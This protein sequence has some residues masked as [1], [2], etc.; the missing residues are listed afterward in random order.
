MHK[1]AL[2]IPPEALTDEDAFELMRFW[3]AHGYPRILVRSLPIFSNMPPACMRNST[4]F[5]W[6]TADTSC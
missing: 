1:N 2:K 3:A 6:V 4:N 5:H